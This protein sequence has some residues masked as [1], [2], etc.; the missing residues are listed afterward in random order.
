MAAPLTALT[1]KGIDFAAAWSPLHAETFDALKNALCAAPVLLLPDFTKP[2]HIVTDASLLGTGGILM[3]DEHV[4]AYTSSKFSPAERNYTTTEQEMLGVIRALEEWRCYVEGNPFVVETDHNALTF[5][6][7]QP[8]MS[9]RMARWVQFLAQ[10]QV[11]LKYRKGTTNMADPLSRSPA[12]LNCMLLAVKQSEWQ[13]TLA[14]RERAKESRRIHNLGA[15]TAQVL[16]ER[17]PRS[18]AQKSDFLQRILAGYQLDPWFAIP[19]NLEKLTLTKGLYF[20]KGTAR[21]VVPNVDTLR[22]DIIRENHN[23]Q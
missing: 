8:T 3:Q 19:R 18:K 10:F 6:D 1:H 2:F 13:S 14:S 11:T 17:K 5:L 22:T 7:T 12:L 23:P 20:F 9:R 4:I 16:E 15:A 21:V